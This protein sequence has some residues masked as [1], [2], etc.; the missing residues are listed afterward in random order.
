MNKYFKSSCISYSLMTSPYSLFYKVCKLK[1]TI[2]P[3]QN[4]PSDFCVHTLT[5]VH[6]QWK[7]YLC[8]LSVSLLDH[9]LFWILKDFVL[10][11]I[12]FLSYII[13]FSL[14]TESFQLAYKCVLIL[15][16]DNNLPKTSPTPCP[17]LVTAPFL[18]SPFFL[19]TPIGTSFPPLHWNGLSRLPSIYLYQ[20]QWSG[21]SSFSLLF[22]FQHHLV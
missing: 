2:T 15:P 1:I 14:S 13:K 6:L 12:P 8:S 4:L 7:K 3:S 20:I 18:P 22:Y 17:S 10:I 19:T 21:L 9:T 11:I 5:C 16:S